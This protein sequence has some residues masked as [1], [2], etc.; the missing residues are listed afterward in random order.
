MA[1]DTVVDGAPP[2]P[3]R[4]SSR[5]PHGTAPTPGQRL[6]PAPGRA[7]R[8]STPSAPSPLPA[9][10]LPYRP[11]LTPCPGLWS[12]QS[13][14]C[15]AE[16]VDMSQMTDIPPTSSLDEDDLPPFWD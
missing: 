12:P 14:R 6:S 8:S 3:L 13:R 15:T 5:R 11:G 16:S 1:D 9:R 7:T 4:P 2:A 10:R